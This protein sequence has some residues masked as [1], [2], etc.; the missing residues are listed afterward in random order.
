[1]EL[2]QEFLEG[3]PRPARSSDRG[4]AR[5]RLQASTIPDRLGP[6]EGKGR[7]YFNAMGHREDVWMSERFQQMIAGAVAWATGGK[8]ADVDANMSKVTPEAGA[9]PPKK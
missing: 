8:N 6:K 5:L 2:A 4:D 7:V 3:H 9:M 1:M